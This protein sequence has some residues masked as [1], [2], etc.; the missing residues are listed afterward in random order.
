MHSRSSKRLFP[1]WKTI[2][3]IVAILGLGSLG[4]NIFAR[5]Y[6]VHA[7]GHRPAD[8]TTP[9]Q[10]IVIL[11][12]ENHT[13]DNFF[14]RFPGANGVTL[15]QATD[16]MPGDIDHSAPA[17]SS[18]LDSGKMDEF[19]A[20]GDVQYTQADVPIYWQYAQ[21]FGLGDDFFSSIAGSST[22]NHVAMVASQSG[23]LDTT[24]FQD[25]CSS[26]PNDLAYS[27]N[28][29]SGASYWAY[30]CFDISSLPQLLEQ[31]GISWR[32]YSQN[33]LW[34][35]P[36]LIK[37]LAGSPDIINSAKQ[38]V[39]DVQAGNMANVSW[40]TPPPGPA[41]SD[42]PPGFEQAAQN[43]IV[44][45]V[46]AVMNSP[47]WSSTAIFITWDDWGGSMTTCS[48]PRLMPWA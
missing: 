28:A 8:A 7:S 36:Q 14:G 33:H 12:M 24:A 38:F 17:L 20:R 40:L 48:L 1:R 39:A 11:M 3:T 21:Q 31:N 29:S 2:L 27:R 4:T 32:Y 45:Q 30:P 42:H 13:F 25:G 34:N 35:A 26:M 19:P 43:Y 44:D 5:N 6:L 23:G 47:Y 10:H 18:A 15:P 41:Q 22:P 16:P 46:N 37:S 9:I